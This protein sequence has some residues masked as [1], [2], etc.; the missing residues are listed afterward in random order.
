MSDGP[1]R[2]LPL[3]SDDSRPFWTEGEHGKLVIEQ[4]ERCAYFIHPPTGFCPRC[5]SR[6]THFEPVSGEG[7]V[8]SY[9]VN[10]RKWMAGLPDR[11]VLAMISL[12]EQPDVRLPTNLVN[13]DPDEVTFDMPVKVLFEQVG[14]IW[15]PLFEPVKP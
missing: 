10:H 14:D 1:E 11:Y 2:A 7:T 6:E 9:S 4:C 15:V 5:E 13:C 3:L 8:E 12:R